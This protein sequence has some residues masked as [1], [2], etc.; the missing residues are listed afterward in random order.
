MESPHTWGLIKAVTGI[1][2]NPLVKLIVY[3][4]RKYRIGKCFQLFMFV[5]TIFNDKFRY[6]T[7]LNR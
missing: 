1:I 5:A 3:S 2:M 7:T 6:D 4:C